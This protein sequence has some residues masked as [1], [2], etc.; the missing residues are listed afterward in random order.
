LTGDAAATVGLL[1]RQSFV[2]EA[3]LVPA[4]VECR[5]AASDVPEIARLLVEARI[6]IHAISPRTGILEALY[7]SHYAN[8]DREAVSGGTRMTSRFGLWRAAAADFLKIWASRG[9]VVFLLAIPAGCYLVVFELYHV[10]R[11][12]EHLVLGHALHAVP[13]LFFGTW[14]LLLFQAAVLAFAAFCATIDSQ[15]GMIR[16]VGVQPLSRVQCLLGKWLGISAHLALV[17]LA[18]VASL[19]GWALLDSG[20]QDIGA[21]DLAR[22]LRFTVELLVWTLALGSVGMATASFRRTIASGMVTAAMS[23]IGLAIMTMLPFDVLPPRYVF[24]RYFFSQCR[25]GRI[26]SPAPVH[27][28]GCTRSPISPSSR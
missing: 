27:S 9:P 26:P 1:R 23:F 5:L 8:A 28:Y 22:L 15:Y 10:E 13:I 21:A 19:V 3:G 12:A 2:H 4:G 18:L 24:V 14:K 25:S 11:V 7:L 17:T 16:V 6:P 20:V